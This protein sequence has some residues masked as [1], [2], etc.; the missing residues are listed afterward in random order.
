MGS[1]PSSPAGVHRTAKESKTKRDRGRLAR[2]TQSDQKMPQNKRTQLTLD[3][4][5]V[6]KTSGPGSARAMRFQ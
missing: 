1:A 6:P 2:E 5:V 3:V 4:S